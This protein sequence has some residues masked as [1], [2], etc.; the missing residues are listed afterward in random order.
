MPDVELNE[1]DFILILIIGYGIGVASGLVFC[2]KYRNVFLTRSKSIDNLKQ[3]NHQNQ[4]SQPQWDSPVL[5]SAPPPLQ[6][7]P[8]ITIE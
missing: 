5:A 2:M 4:V 8:K 6:N 7:L 3:H 1:F